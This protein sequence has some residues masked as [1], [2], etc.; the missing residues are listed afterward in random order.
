MRREFVV[1]RNGM[2]VGIFDTA[3]DA[4][5]AMKNLTVPE[6]P[7]TLKVL[8]IGGVRRDKGEVDK[9]GM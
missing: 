7:G 9:T 4:E 5:T 2:I 1:I 3:K 6:P 8:E